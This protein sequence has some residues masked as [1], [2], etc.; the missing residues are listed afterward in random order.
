MINSE[1][2][3]NADMRQGVS[4]GSFKHLAPNRGGQ[5]EMERPLARAA[6]FSPWRYDF[7]EAGSKEL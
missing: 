5:V 7:E 1:R 3:M 4:D 6:V 2:S